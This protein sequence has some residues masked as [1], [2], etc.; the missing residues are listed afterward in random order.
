[1]G[2]ADLLARPG[3][4][5][6]PCDAGVRPEHTIAAKLLDRQFGAMAPNCKWAADFTSLWTAEGWL[7]VAVVMTVFSRRIIG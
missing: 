3:R 2:T 4:R 7:F 1:M 6:R 5:R